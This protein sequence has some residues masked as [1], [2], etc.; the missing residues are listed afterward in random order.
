MTMLKRTILTIILS[1][2]CVLPL[3]GQGAVINLTQLLQQAEA[4]DAQAQLLLSASYCNGLCGLT[5]DE[6]MAFRWGMK[7]ASQGNLDAI[8]IVGYYYAAGIGVKLNIPEADKYFEKFYSA[9]G[10]NKSSV[11]FVPPSADEMLGVFKETLYTIAHE[12]YN[13]SNGLTKDYARAAHWLH[14][15]IDLGYEKALSLLVDIYYF[16]GYG[17]SKNYAEVVRLTQKSAERGVEEFQLLIGNIY[18]R[19]GY[20]V[21]KNLVES[22]RWYRKASP[23]LEKLWLEFFPDEFEF[24]IARDFIERYWYGRG[25]SQNREEALY[26]YNFVKRVGKNTKITDAIVGGATEQQI[27]QMRSATNATPSVS[28][29]NSQSGTTTPTS[30]TSTST[31][32]SS[33]SS[34][35]S[36]SSTT[37]STYHSLGWVPSPFSTLRDNVKEWWTDRHGIYNT[38]YG[39]LLF[40]YA[41]S[42]NQDPTW[43]VNMGFFGRKKYG[44]LGLHTSL[45]M[46]GGPDSW[47]LRAGPLLRFG[48]HTNDVEWQLYAGVGPHWDTV[49]HSPG[50]E[51]TCYFSWEA[52][53]RANITDLAD[54]RM[55]SL[56][57]V[58]LG[59][60]FV[61]DE[62]VPTI[63]LSLWPA[64][65]FDDF[66][67]DFD[68]DLDLGFGE[69]YYTLVGEFMSAF[70]DGALM[71][72][73]LAWMPSKLGW[74]A[75][76][77]GAVDANGNTFTTGPV[78]SM[79]EG[80]ASVYAGLGNVAGDFGFDVG[81]RGIGSCSLSLGFQS[82]TED[83]FITIGCGFAF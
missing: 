58:S 73:S 43:G 83:S 18:Y 30:T 40:G 70:G 42:D 11:F 51:T 41:I 55:L 53:V 9:D 5:K 29:T 78:W 24:D 32:T 37:S 26:W 2:L 62:I 19:G 17:V 50:L 79:R 12:Y 8:L 49:N 77:L 57:S 80:V 54:D 47:G 64:L 60:Q 63:G 48:D 44:R 65:L 15:L 27:A 6:D 67:F 25:L 81:I 16:G 28:S 52:G 71:G 56:A 39:E 72:A 34:S 31:S 76:M 69:N 21:L 61:M 4:G 22:A 46:M 13:G 7:A 23:S 35:L 82:N 59:C 33:S 38:I 45:S 36:Y 1:T 66:D 14:R 3:C 20:G 75:S 10:I 68:L 74:Y